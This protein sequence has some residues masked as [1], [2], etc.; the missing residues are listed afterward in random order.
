MKKILFALAAC[1]LV[2]TAALAQPMPPRHG[3][4][5]GYD[6]PHHRPHK[7]WVPAHREHGRMVRGHYDYR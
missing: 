7:V 6:R 2:S 3:P 5:P 1:A 4:G